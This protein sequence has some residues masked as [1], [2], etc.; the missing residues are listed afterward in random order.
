MPKIRSPENDKF[1]T[2]DHQP[3]QGQKL[4]LAS[5][6]PTRIKLL[7]HAGLTFISQ[8]HNIDEAAE[9]ALRAH[10]PASLLAIE[11]AKLK[12]LSISKPQAYIIG[13]D[14]TLDC[15]GITYH[16]PKDKVEAFEQLTSLRGKT[17]TLNSALAIAHENEILWQHSTQAHLTM[18]DFS[19]AF[20]AVYIEAN[21]KNI[22]STVGCYQLEGAG[23]NL[24]EKI[25]GDYFTILGLPLLPCL[26]YLRGLGFSQS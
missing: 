23:I 1:S 15:C 14:Q 20:L 17:H 10:V 25:E 3:V 24:F 19:D 8:T 5:N 16:K 22:L 12:A 7:K 6:S 2:S 21:L 9:Q 4:I 26:A 13:A 18:R 11:L